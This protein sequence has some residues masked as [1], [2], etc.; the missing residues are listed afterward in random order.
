MH[1]KQLLKENFMTRKPVSSSVLKSV[2]YD[3]ESAILELS[4]RDG[5]VN[6]YFGVRM[7]THSGLMSAKS[8]RE[9]FDKNIR[10]LYAS[11]MVGRN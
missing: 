3:P 11:R 7:H 1:F 10:N 8:K 9:F 4:F 2:G 5:L 6:Q